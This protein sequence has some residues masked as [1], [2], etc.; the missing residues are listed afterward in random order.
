MSSRDRL[1]KIDRTARSMPRLAGV[2]WLL[3]LGWVAATVGYFGSWLAHETAALTLSGVDMAEFVKFLPEVL[4]GTLAVIRQLFYLPPFAV[5]VCVALLVG[6]GTLRYPVWFRVL[7]LVGAM[8]VSLQL[9]PPAW[10]VSSLMSPEFR[11]QAVALGAS[12]LLLAGFWMLGRL[13]LWLTSAAAGA[14]SLI[15]MVLPAWQVLIAKPAI[16]VV[17]L[18]APGIGWGFL[19]CMA[20][21]AVMTAVSALLFVQA[22]RQSGTSWA[23]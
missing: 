15:A 19:V 20:G 13:P 3:P 12:W 4:D 8:P 23:G 9:L 7:A 11:L 21:L 5:V 6:S 2:R 14:I 1:G 18:S 22:R 16:D 10:S 17:Y